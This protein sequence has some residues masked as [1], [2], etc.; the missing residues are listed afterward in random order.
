VTLVLG[1]TFSVL[2]FL[3]AL[4]FFEQEPGGKDALA[5]PHGRVDFVWAIV[6]TYLTIIF[7]IHK[8]QSK[9]LA[10]KN[11]LEPFNRWLLVLSLVFGS[12]ISTFS[13]V[14]FMPYYRYAFNLL[15]ACCLS[16]WSFLCWCL[17]FKQ[18][19]P[20]SDIG[21]VYFCF[22]PFVIVQTGFI[23]NFRRRWL[24]KAEVRHVQDPLSVELKARF[25]LE[26][27]GI[28]FKGLE[29]SENNQVLNDT[30]LFDQV[31][32]INTL[33]VDAT[34]LIPESPL[35]YAFWA[36]FQLL[37]LKNKHMC[38]ANY[39]KVETLSS[40]IDLQFMAFRRRQ[41][42]SENF[43]GK[44]GDAIKFIEYEQYSRQAAKHQAKVTRDQ[45]RFW[46]ELLKRQT[47]ISRLHSLAESI[48][49]EV[50]L[51]QENYVKMLKLN[52]GSAHV[53]RLYAQFLIEFLNDRKAGQELQE[54][55]DDL[56]VGTK[57]EEERGNGEEAVEFD[58]FSSDNMI[59][60]ISGDP[61]NIGVI[62]QA[63]EKALNILGYR[64]SE[65][66]HRNISLI[67]P[68]PFSVYHD[69]F[70]HRFLSTGVSKIVEKTRKVIMKRYNGYL[71]PIMLAV[72]QITYK[73]KAA[74]LGVIRPIFGP[75]D[76][77]ILDGK[78]EN[79]LSFS[80]GISRWFGKFP[81][82]IES[83]ALNISEI[84][85]NYDARKKE[86]W[87][88]SGH[89]E[90]FIGAQGRMKVEAQIITSEI[91]NPVDKGAIKMNMVVLRVSPDAVK[92]EPILN[93]DKDMK[94]AQ[95]VESLESTTSRSQS[96]KSVTKSFSSRKDM[97]MG[98]VDDTSED[99]ST[100]SKA[101][102][103]MSDNGGGSVARSS[104]SSSST[105]PEFMKS[106]IVRKNV[107]VAKHLRWLRLS[108]LLIACILI[109][110]AV[111][112]H[113]TI[114]FLYGTYSSE[115]QIVTLE[116]E[117][118]VCSTSLAFFSR[119]LELSHSGTLTESDGRDAIKEIQAILDRVHTSTQRMEDIQTSD[120]YF[121][122]FYKA[123]K[124]T[125]LKQ[126]ADGNVAYTIG[127]MDAMNSLESTASQLIQSSEP[128]SRHMDFIIR[129]GAKTIPNAFEKH[130]T[131]QLSILER[132]DWALFNEIILCIL[133]IAIYL[134]TVYLILIPI[135]KVIQKE[136]DNF[137]LMFSSIPRQVVKGIYE[138]WIR[139]N[140]ILCGND[141]DMTPGLLNPP[142]I[143]DT[144]F[145]PSIA[146]TLPGSVVSAAAAKE[147]QLNVIGRGGNPSS[148][149]KLDLTW[150]KMIVDKIQSFILG[151]SGAI[152]FG[153]LNLFDPK[154]GVYLLLALAYFV[155]SAA[156]V[157]FFQTSLLQHF[158]E[159]KWITRLAYISRQLNFYLRE[160]LSPISSA[161][162]SPSEALSM[163]A[164]C[165]ERIKG[166]SEDLIYG[167][168]A[169]GLQGMDFLTE[170]LRN[171]LLE[172]GW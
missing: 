117:L 43:T 121:E 5:R 161:R 114:L 56:E 9:E 93:N 137:L 78:G 28:L 10:F 60:T 80:E 144:G 3:V 41:M 167:N 136:R 143:N 171:T 39:A 111:R 76:F 33:Y 108:F 87:S 34:R 155:A 156:M 72:K 2:T 125:L 40:R 172:A 159:V 148:N 55:A 7:T 48:S 22:L 18:F 168:V 4:T 139:R 140:E 68:M 120:V 142:A 160:A 115:I 164:V 163:V 138:Q 104:K 110:L 106:I 170:A 169:E 96:G 16:S 29:I 42:L 19:R 162:F 14:W 105:S 109:S 88:P 102:R 166:I 37:F 150:N 47:E 59:I 129:N 71:M 64:R 65:L 116:H 50:T 58:P 26:D 83:R 119:T 98:F 15:Q 53:L 153:I 38:L 97:P 89:I 147:K 85:P 135:Y 151:V 146:K 152:K 69:E 79:A 75:D 77:I 70:M 73:N 157:H 94:T 95:T 62:L 74:F 32:D 8:R 132:I 141:D 128:S 25:M 124:L 126:T 11:P 12:S 57:D 86:Y 27:K 145:D 165:N 63:N 67:V 81:Q 131:S 134:I 23:M 44:M 118:A 90:S 31:K 1:S 30:A 103:A 107:V 99:G 122:Q 17:L 6:R 149:G 130:T 113:Y 52:P 35:L 127:L 84:L 20:N 54:R 61:E 112:G 66:V 21:I 92:E 91:P 46:G 45:I 123:N 51:T 13:F 100:S 154:Y 158:A 49:Q 133:P 101:D 36:E 24:I 82:E